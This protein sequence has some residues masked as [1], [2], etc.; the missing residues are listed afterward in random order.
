MRDYPV[1]RWHAGEDLLARRESALLASW[2]V[3]VE[4][5][6]WGLRR[7]GT[8]MM[9]L[10]AATR[11]GAMA[12]G[13]EQVL[14]PARHSDIPAEDDY[15]LVSVTAGRAECA[16]CC[17]PSSLGS[18]SSRPLLRSREGGG[19][20]PSTLKTMFHVKH[21]GLNREINPRDGVGTVMRCPLPS[22]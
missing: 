3:H 12:A 1:A 8:L 21:L 15:R 7:F 6:R 5:P 14:I 2:F 4:T 19:D 22:D 18:A 10:R 13:R 20:N 9:C 16:A 11:L 17:R